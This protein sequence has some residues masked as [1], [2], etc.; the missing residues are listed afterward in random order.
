MAPIKK[1]VERAWSDK[2]GEPRHGFVKTQQNVIRISREI[3]RDGEVF[4]YRWLRPDFR[5]IL[6]AAMNYF[7]IT[8]NSIFGGIYT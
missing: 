7:G 8:Y 2:V 5:S 3:F 6:L 1:V 4:F